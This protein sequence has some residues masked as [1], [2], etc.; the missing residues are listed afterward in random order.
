MGDLSD[1]EVKTCI[2][3]LRTNPGVPPVWVEE[4]SDSDVVLGFQIVLTCAATSHPP[5]RVTWR[6]IQGDT[7]SGPTPGVVSNEDPSNGFMYSN[8]RWVVSS[9]GSLIVAQAQESDAGIYACQVENGI[10]PGLSKNIGLKI[11]VPPKVSVP[12]GQLAI[13][14]GEA[15][16]LVCDVTGDGPI[17]VK[18]VKKQNVIEI[19]PGSRFEANQRRSNPSTYS[20]Q[21]QYTF[22]L[23]VRDSQQADGGTYSCVAKNDY[24]EHKG[25]VTLDVLARLYYFPPN[26]SNLCLSNIKILTILLKSQLILVFKNSPILSFFNKRDIPSPFRLLSEKA[27]KVLLTSFPFSSTEPYSRTNPHPPPS[28]PTP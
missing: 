11:N 25:E 24:G 27:I 7:N 26:S 21:D 18:W 17:H 20:K 12:K 5:P 28:T 19:H 23:L 4:P 10:G 6:K 22:E 3:K 8:P 2:L 1:E 9:N 14:K 15:A 13:R 16:R